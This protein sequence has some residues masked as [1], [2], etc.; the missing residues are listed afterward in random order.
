MVDIAGSLRRILLRG[1]VFLCRASGRSHMRVRYHD[2]RLELPLDV[3]TPRIARTFETNCCS[4]EARQAI[5]GVVRK[6]DTVLAIAAACL[7]GVSRVMLERHKHIVGFD[8]VRAVFAS[9]AREGFACNRHLGCANVVTFDRC[10]R[11]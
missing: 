6:G 8:G 3:L 4:S 1:N 5:A 7:D 11:Q 9:L 2:V 10:V